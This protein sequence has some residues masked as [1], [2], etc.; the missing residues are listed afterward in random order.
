MYHRGIDGLRPGL[1][2][3]PVLPML[4]AFAF[5]LISTVMQSKI[6]E[7]GEVIWMVVGSAACVISG[8][9]TNLAASALV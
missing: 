3:G 8:L 6:D 5:S 2:L 4:L 7:G 9:A 1:K